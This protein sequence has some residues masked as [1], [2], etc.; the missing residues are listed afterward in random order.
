VLDP[1]VERKNMVLGWA[2]FAVFLL[3][4]AGTVLVAL[5]YLAVD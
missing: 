2:L 4:F 3:L 5:I 1:E